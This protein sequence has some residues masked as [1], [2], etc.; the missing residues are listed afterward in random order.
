MY[1]NCEIA[2]PILQKGLPFY[3]TL[4]IISIY[5]MIPFKGTIDLPTK[6][7]LM[8]LFRCHFRL[9]PMIAI[10]FRPD[11]ISIQGPAGDVVGLNA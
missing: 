4:K 3:V 10:R 6:F 5:K 1:C 9:N 7:D 11:S 2:H 8:P